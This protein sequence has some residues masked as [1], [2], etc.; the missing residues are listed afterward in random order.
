MIKSQKVGCV[1]HV[2]HAQILWGRAGSGGGG[3]GWFAPGDASSR[4][5]V[6][7]E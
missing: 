2:L 1:A 4:C 5:Y 7:M 3:G 6:N